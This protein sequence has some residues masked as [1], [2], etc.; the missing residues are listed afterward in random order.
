MKKFE[1]LSLKQ[2]EF[3]E[4]VDTIAR[5]R[6]TLKTKKKE[7]NFIIVTCQIAIP[8]A[9]IKYHTEEQGDNLNVYRKVNWF[10]LIYYALP[11]LLILE[12]L[13]YLIS[14]FTRNIQWFSYL[15][16]GLTWCLGI[17]FIIYQ[18]FSELENLTQNLFRVK[19]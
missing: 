4:M 14:Y 6:T 19:V 3:I 5:E 11:I 18:I 13:L 1:Y 17:V 8:V 10:P 15:L 16:L 2:N 7:E 12:S 9:K